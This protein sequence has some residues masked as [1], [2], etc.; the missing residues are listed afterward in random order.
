MKFCLW[1]NFFLWHGRIN[2]ETEQ[3]ALSNIFINKIGILSTYAVKI[4][5]YLIVIR[6]QFNVCRGKKKN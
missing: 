3:Y 6:A 2:T 4:K 5:C 1:V